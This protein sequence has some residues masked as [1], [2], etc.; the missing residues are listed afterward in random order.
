MLLRPLNKNDVRQLFLIEQRTQQS[1]WSEE[2]FKQ[3]ILENYEG[4]VI[5]E[6]EII[7]GF[8]MMSLRAG[9]SHILNLGIQPEFQRQ[10]HASR[11]LQHALEE[12]RKKGAGISYLEVRSSNYKAIALY[13]KFGFIQIGT[14]KDYYTYP[15]GKEDAFV[16]AKDLIVNRPLS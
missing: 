8:V 16:F 5:E 3:C 12:A 2:V 6:N 7:I 11:L 10:G 1:P 9:E 15:L 4:W 13:K 14:R